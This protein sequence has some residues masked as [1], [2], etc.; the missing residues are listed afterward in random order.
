MITRSIFGISSFNCFVAYILNPY[1]YSIF[2]FIFQASSI[3]KLVCGTNYSCD[4]ID[5][6]TLVNSVAVL[7]NFLYL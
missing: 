2:L 7:C 5:L 1:L 6:G 4:Y 3:R